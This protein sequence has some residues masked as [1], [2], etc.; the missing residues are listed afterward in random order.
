MDLRPHL[1]PQRRKRP[2]NFAFALFERSDPSRRKTFRTPF[3]GK[4][5]PPHPSFEERRRCGDSSNAPPPTFEL[6]N[7]GE[8]GEWGAHLHNF[9]KTKSTA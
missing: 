6:T 3:G 5:A 2:N 1:P 4:C 9:I 8:R 7:E